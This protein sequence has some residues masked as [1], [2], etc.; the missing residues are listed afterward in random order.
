[1]ISCSSIYFCPSFAL[2]CPDVT[3][4]YPFAHRC[5]SHY[6]F[7]IP[8][9]HLAV[10][11][12]SF[13]SYIVRPSI[14]GGAE[15][16]RLAYVR[17]P[18]LHFRLLR[19]RNWQRISPLS[20]LY[21]SLQYY[22]I[23]SYITYTMRTSFV[24]RTS[25]YTKVFTQRRGGSPIPCFRNKWR[26]MQNRHNISDVLW[27]SRYCQDHKVAR[28]NRWFVSAVLDIV[29]RLVVARFT[30]ILRK[31]GDCHHRFR[32]WRSI[33]NRHVKHALYFQSTINVYCVFLFIPL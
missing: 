28:G 30:R 13:P 32:R 14:P 20:P 6:R 16:P 26:K 22:C 11:C 4:K 12:Y 23:S 33:A 3:T 27:K 9:T 2:I 17:D 5:C 31:A 24:Y 8:E 10:S 25:R 18:D 7:L 19:L 29:Y 21:P 15:V 1:M